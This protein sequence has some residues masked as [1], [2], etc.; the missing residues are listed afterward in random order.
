MPF[1]HVTLHQVMKEE[2]ML[3][4]RSTLIPTRRGSRT[5]VQMNEV[6]GMLPITR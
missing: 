5:Y 3:Q 2:S 4:I 1:H 6:H